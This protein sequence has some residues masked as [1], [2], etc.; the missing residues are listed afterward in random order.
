MALSTRVIERLECRH[1]PLLQFECVDLRRWNCS[2]CAQRTAKRQV[3]T[4]PDTDWR[5]SSLTAARDPAG[6]SVGESDAWLEGTSIF[7]VAASAS[8]SAHMSVPADVPNWRVHY[9]LWRIVTFAPFEHILRD[10]G[11]FSIEEAS[12]QRTQPWRRVGRSQRTSS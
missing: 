6:A 12:S 9:L 8:G 2:W 5:P 3:A 10:P 11:I 7:A 1:D 4:W